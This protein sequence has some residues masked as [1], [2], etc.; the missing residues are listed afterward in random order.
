[1]GVPTFN[2]CWFRIKKWLFWLTWWLVP[3]LIFKF[4]LYSLTWKEFQT[5]HV[6][7]LSSEIA[8]PQF[9]GARGVP[10]WNYRCSAL[11][12]CIAQGI[13]HRM[14]WKSSLKIYLFIFWAITLEFSGYVLFWISKNRKKLGPRFSKLN[15]NIL[16]AYL[17]LL[18]E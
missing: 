16:K 12:C 11:M 7:F 8:A 5:N 2:I 18:P 15:N 9:K 4:I 1:M 17:K 13:F 14:S 3:F 10:S 6:Q